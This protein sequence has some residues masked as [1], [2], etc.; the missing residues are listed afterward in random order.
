[1]GAEFKRAG[2]ERRG[3]TC[4]LGLE[5]TMWGTRVCCISP[6]NPHISPC[7]VAAALL[8]R[9][10]FPPPYGS[11]RPFSVTSA[12]SLP[13]ESPDGTTEVDIESMADFAG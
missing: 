12:L 11:S 8:L 1:M 7:I 2:G 9:L 5:G 10:Y 3:W 6:G 13:P 4:P